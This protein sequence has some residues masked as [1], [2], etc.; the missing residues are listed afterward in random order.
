MSTV[1]A[2]EEAISFEIGIAVPLES[3][4]PFLSGGGG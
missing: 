4:F 1:L 2:M 3:D